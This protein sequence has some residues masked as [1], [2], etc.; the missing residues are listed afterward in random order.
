MAM[1][2]TLQN[3][4]TGELSFLTCFMNFAGSIGKIKYMPKLVT[5]HY[6]LPSG[7]SSLLILLLYNTIFQLNS[8][9][10]WHFVEFIFGKYLA[11][12]KLMTLLI[13]HTHLSLIN[14]LFNQC[15]KLVNLWY[16]FSC[17]KSF[18]Q[19]P[20]EDSLKW[21]PWFW[22]QLQFSILVLDAPDPTAR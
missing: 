14:K 9:G 18:Y 22:L 15:W 19:H 1:Q 17:S 11:W 10:I 21:Y 8:I 13:G 20:G 4:G 5:N 7:S 16:N 2:C 6:V 12:L 3:K